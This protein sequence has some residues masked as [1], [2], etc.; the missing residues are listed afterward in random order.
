MVDIERESRGTQ[1]AGIVPPQAIQAERAI[2]AAMML[3]HDSVGRA[4]ESIGPGVFYRTSHQKIFDAVVA[5][6][7]RQEPVDLITVSEELRKQGNL[8]AIGGAA[9][10]AGVFE[11]ATTSANLDAHVKI[12]AEKA[13]LRQMIKASTEIQ[14]E[15]YAGGTETAEILD[16]AESRI[17]A[18]SDKQVRQG[19]MPL[20]ELLKGTFKEVEALSERK[21]RITGVPT[22]YKDLD[23]ITLGFQPSDLI[24]IA[25]RPAMG[26]SSLAVNIAENAAIKY[27]VHV[28]LFSLEMS[29]IQLALRMLGSQSDVSLHK[30]RSGFLSNE[31]W[32]KLTTGAGLLA[33]APIWI[34]DTAAPTVLQL[35]AKCRRLSAEASLGLVVIDYLQLIQ[36]VGSSENRVQEISQITRSLKA[37][38]KELKVPIVALSQLSRAVEQRG[39][40]K[41]PQLSDLRESGSIEQDSDLVMFVF[42]EEY[43]KP[44]DPA[45]HGK[46]EIIV[47][48]HR[49]GPTGSVDLTFIREQTKFVDYAAVMPGETEPGF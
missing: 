11:E 29:N 34:D 35:R 19:L 13:L 46:A 38:A 15:C 18:I 24:I 16:R 39:T 49:N 28:A 20:K 32:P 23:S 6:Y 27:G 48:K 37:L 26:K 21:Q 25:G 42:R 8:E 12:V 31:D 14:Q 40:D 10:L 1:Q 22:G 9:Y 43:Y 41:R 7:N 45:L 17:F 5:L 3:G 30:L 44:D 4:L 36:A 33:S 2:L 47:A